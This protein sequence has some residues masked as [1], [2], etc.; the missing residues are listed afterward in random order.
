ML[1]KIHTDEPFL[2]F[3]CNHLGPALFGAQRRQEAKGAKKKICVALL[4]T[5]RSLLLCDFAR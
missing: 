5:W 1:S 4:L 2:I 3:S